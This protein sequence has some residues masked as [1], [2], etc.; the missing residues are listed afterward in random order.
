MAR[1]RQKKSEP[2]VRVRM[3]V[4]KGDK[5][6]VR[7]GSDRSKEPRE[8][9][10]VNAETGRIVVKDVNMRW[11]HERRTKENPQGGRVRKEFPIHHSRVLLWSEKAGK[12]VRTKTE[13]IDGKRVRVGIPCGTR[14]D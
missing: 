5:V 14:F 10:E 3:H 13:W 6:V 8:V 11:K 9:L 7:T 1:G 12:G 4:K 2:G